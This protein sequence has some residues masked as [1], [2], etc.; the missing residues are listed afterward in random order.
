MTRAL[1]A[2]LETS[3]VG[4]LAW[5]AQGGAAHGP[6]LP[7]GWPRLAAALPGAGWPLGTLIEILLPRPGVGELSL[8]LPALRAATAPG[9]DSPR[10]LSWIGPPHDPY[11][12]ALAQAGVPAERLLVG[13]VGGERE[14][15]WAI[16]QAIASQGCAAVLAWCAGAPGQS[17][18][19]L[20]L[21]AARGRTLAVLFRPLRFRTEPSPASLRLALLPTPLGPTLDVLKRRGGGPVRVADV[22]GP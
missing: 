1:D 13:R 15:L 2:L 7:A 5:R 3:A 10:W 18:R 17:L 20:K 4:A 8:L 19:R 12:P 6:V 9:S 22:F 16:E 21:A 14:R 11:A